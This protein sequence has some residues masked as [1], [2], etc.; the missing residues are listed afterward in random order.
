[1]VRGTHH[2]LSADEIR[3]HVRCGKQVTQLGLIYDG[4]ISF[5]LD[6]N[7]KLRKLQFLDVIADRVDAGDGADPDQILDAEFF[8]MSAELS[9]LFLALDRVLR[10]V[11]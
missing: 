8:L 9:R 6:D 2:D 1:M 7:M 11:D 5:V 4:R 3:E 10:F